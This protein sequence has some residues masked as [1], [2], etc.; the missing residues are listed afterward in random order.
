MKSSNKVLTI[1]VILLLLVNIALVVFLVMG[2]NSSDARGRNGGPFDMMIKELGMS[3]QQKANFE[4]LRD[5]H[6]KGLR[7]I[8][9]SIRVAKANYFGLTKDSSI[10]DSVLDRYARHIT[11]LQMNMYKLTVSHFQRVR[12]LF[13]GEQQKKFDDFVQK[14][15]Q[16]NPG[17]MRKKDSTSRAR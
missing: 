14:M 5:E 11:G 9:D 2:R 1:A 10:S 12:A 8:F 4:K 6:F 17:S 16:R 7:P 15:M 13:E 3:D